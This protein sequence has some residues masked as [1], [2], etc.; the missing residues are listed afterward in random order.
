MDFVETSIKK[1][2]AHEIDNHWTL[3]IIRE[4]NGK[5][6]VMYVWKLK[7]K[8]APYGRLIKYKD[9]LCAHGGMQKWGVNLWET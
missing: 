1:K 5:D 9:L 8:R 2:G 7:R 3:V 6:I 4:L